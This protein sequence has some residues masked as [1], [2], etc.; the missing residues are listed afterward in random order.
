MGARH[1]ASLLDWAHVVDLQFRR[2]KSAPAAEMA[3]QRDAD[4]GVGQRC[5]HAAVKHSRVVAQLGREIA[6]Y[7]DSVGMHIDHFEAEMRIEIGAYKRTAKFFK[8]HVELTLYYRIYANP[9]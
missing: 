7:A 8:G 2:C 1:D 4:R 5:G 6:G 9:G 3:S